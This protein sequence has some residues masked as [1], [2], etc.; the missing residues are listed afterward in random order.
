MKK[1]RFNRR[2]KDKITK[3][4]YQANEVKTFADDERADEI[5]ESGY[6]E[7]VEESE[8]QEDEWVDKLP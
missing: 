2:C 1:I 5:I 7:E 4:I 6:A 3:Q 8:E